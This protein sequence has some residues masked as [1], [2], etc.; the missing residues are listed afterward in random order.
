MEIPSSIN[1]RGNLSKEAISR[2][3]ININNNNKKDISKFG[4]GGTLTYDEFM[5][6]IKQQENKCY[7][8]LQEL[9]YNGGKWCNFFPSADRIS[10]NTRHCNE[11]IAISCVYCNIRYFKEQ[12]LETDVYKKCGLCPGLDHDFNGHIISKRELYSNL[13]HSDYRIK[14]YI[15]NINIQHNNTADD[16]PS[17]S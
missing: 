16:N 12:Y 7:I 8:C 5:N 13:G 9:K 4:V 11:N 6:K 2:I 10:N 14:E 15:N 17:N 1:I 3:K